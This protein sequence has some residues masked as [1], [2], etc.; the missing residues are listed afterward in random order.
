MTAHSLQITGL[1]SKLAEHWKTYFSRTSAS[2]RDEQFN[3]GHLTIQ[4]NRL[5]HSVIWGRYTTWN[6]VASSNSCCNQQSC[7]LKT[8][9]PPLGM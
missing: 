7:T 3:Q 1:F 6:G 8:E 9:S 4:L 2:L 5:K